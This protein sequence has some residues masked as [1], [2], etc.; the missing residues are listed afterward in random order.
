MLIWLAAV[1]PLI[2]RNSLLIRMPPVSASATEGGGRGESRS[3]APLR[4]KDVPDDTRF[5]TTWHGR[6]ALALPFVFRVLFKLGRSHIRRVA[7][8]DD[9][10]AR[11]PWSFYFAG[12]WYLGSGLLVLGT[13]TLANTSPMI[14][15][16]LGELIP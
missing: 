8:S 7:P 12:I 3:Y 1:L 16:I 5:P 13:L 15:R 6:L 10:S 4:P 2:V 14:N 9:L 11:D